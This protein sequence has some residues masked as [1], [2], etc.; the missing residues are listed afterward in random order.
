V[1]DT[2]ITERVNLQFRTEFSNPFNRVVFANPIQTLTD[3]RF[4]RITSVQTGPREIQF[5]LK[6]MW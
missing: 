2:Q 1:K 4:G 6:L 5:G 3:S